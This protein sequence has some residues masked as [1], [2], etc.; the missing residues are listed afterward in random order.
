MAPNDLPHYEIL[1][2]SLTTKEYLF[3][4]ISKDEVCKYVSAILITGL[5]FKIQIFYVAVKDKVITKF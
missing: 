2:K 5:I 3:R 1:V 4:N